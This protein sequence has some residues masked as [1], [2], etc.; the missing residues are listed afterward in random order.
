MWILQSSST[1]NPTK[2]QSH[3]IYTM[4]IPRVPIHKDGLHKVYFTCN[5]CTLYNFQVTR[6]VITTTPKHT[7][8]VRSVEWRSQEKSNATTTKLMW[9]HLQ[10]CIDTVKMPFEYNIYLT[11]HKI[12]SYTSTEPNNVVAN[13]IL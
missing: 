13:C 5:K 4:T 3:D 8:N 9:L 2:I 10:Q 12:Q 1:Q 6:L 11:V 7:N